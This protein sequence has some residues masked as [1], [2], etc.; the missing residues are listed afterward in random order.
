MKQSCWRKRW[1]CGGQ[2]TGSGGDR[3]N[4]TTG[5]R[6]RIEYARVPG[7]LWASVV[8]GGCRVL[9]GRVTPKWHPAQPKLCRKVS[10]SWGAAAQ[11]INLRVPATC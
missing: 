8:G 9:E 3:V 5:A 4:R 1:A 11:G 6:R 7:G 10:F 2:T